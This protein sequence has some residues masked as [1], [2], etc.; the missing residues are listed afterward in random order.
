MASLA[1]KTMRAMVLRRLGDEL[2]LERLPRPVPGINQVQIQVEA[3]GFLPGP[4]P[5]DKTGLIRL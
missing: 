2:H 3:C 5:H 1:P 4:P